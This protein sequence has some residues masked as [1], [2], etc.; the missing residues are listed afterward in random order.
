LYGFF[1][2]HIIPYSVGSILFIIL[3]MVIVA[4]LV[5]A[6]RYKQEGRG[7]DS[8]WYHWINYL[9]RYEKTSSVRINV[10]EVFKRHQ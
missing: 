7:F 3:C 9:N 2:Y 6:L 4:Q 8:R 10:Y 1:L 5:E